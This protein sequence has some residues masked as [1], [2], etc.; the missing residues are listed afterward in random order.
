MKK[1]QAQKIKSVGDIPSARFGHT[2]TMIGQG[3]A[4]L[5][6]GA[7]SENG[8]FSITNDTFLYDIPLKRWKRVSNIKGEIPGERAAH[9][10]AAISST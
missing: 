5:F 3:K 4:I 10:A 2:L 1:L 7:I 9:A 8:R 6:G